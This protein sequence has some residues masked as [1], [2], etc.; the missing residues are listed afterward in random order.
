MKKK[1]K[2][3]IGDIKRATSR[4]SETY[5][6]DEYWDDINA[7]TIDS[8]ELTVYGEEIKEPIINLK[9]PYAKTT[10]RNNL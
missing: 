1:F 6:P 9:D 10:H 8:C 5:I 7:I 3:T 2:I 4:G